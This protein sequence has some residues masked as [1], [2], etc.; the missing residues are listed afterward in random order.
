MALT[1]LNNQSL[2]A[3]T[4]AGIPVSAGTVLQTVSAT[5]ATATSITSTT[6]GSGTST[7]LTV[8]ITP[9]SITNKMLISYVGYFHLATHSAPAVSVEF[10]DGSSVVATDIQWGI[11][12]NGDGN[13]HNNRWRYP[14]MAFVTPSSS[15]AI[16]YTVRAWKSGNAVTAQYQ[17]GPS[18]ISI[19]E[20]AG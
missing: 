3:V 1:K 12:I 7:G 14:F 20:I 5:Y 4:S 13:E 16:T 9:K 8:T 6:G 10:Y 11:Y 2:S 18:T 19:Q 17:N 15:G